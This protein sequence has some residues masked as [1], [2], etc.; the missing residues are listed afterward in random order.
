MPTDCFW[1]VCCWT[2]KS[3]MCSCK[4]AKIGWLATIEQLSPPL[5]TSSG[6]H[7]AVAMQSL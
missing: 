5:I 7:D 1:N 2:R 4:V 6:A 3:I